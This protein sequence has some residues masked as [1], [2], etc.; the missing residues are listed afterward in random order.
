MLDGLQYRILRRFPSGGGDGS[1]YTGKPKL[2]V[3]LGCDLFDRMRGQVVIDFGCG[4]GNEAMEFVQRGVRW[5]IGIDIDE[6]RLRT[7]RASGGGWRRTGLP[8]CPVHR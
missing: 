2:E 6:D 8:I 4:D 3:L 5:V 1:F 7:A